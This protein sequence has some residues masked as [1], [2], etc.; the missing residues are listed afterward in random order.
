M[1]LAQGRQLELLSLYRKAVVSGF[2]DVERALIS[3][4]DSA[5]RE[6]LQQQVVDASRRAFNIADTRL[7]EGTVDLVTVLITQQ[8]LFTAEENRVTARLARLQAVLSLYQALGGSWLPKPDV[9]VTTP[10]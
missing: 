8:A 3:V 6:R 10:Q 2:T 9:R 4:R 7:R 5:E 1:E